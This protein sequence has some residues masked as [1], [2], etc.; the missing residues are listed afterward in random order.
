[1][2]QTI[3]VQLL[4]FGVT[5]INE[6]VRHNDDDSYTILLNSRQAS[7]RLKDAYKHALGHIS[8]G[9]CDTRDGLVQSIETVAHQR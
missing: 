9:E 5:S 6:L 1:M 4:D 3:N 2:K 8:N 7:N